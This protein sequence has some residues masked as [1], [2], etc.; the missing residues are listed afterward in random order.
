MGNNVLAHV[1]EINRFLGA[2]AA[3]LKPEGAA[4]FE[5]PYLAELLDKIEFDTIYH[6]HV[7]YYSLSSISNLAARANLEVFDVTQQAIHGGSLRVF[8]QHRGARPI[9][10]RVTKMLNGERQMGL[11]DPAHYNS[12]GMR[13]GELKRELLALLRSLKSEGKRLAAYGAPAKGNT[14]LNY[15]GIGTELLDFTVDMSPHKQGLYLP[16][17]RLPILAPSMLL[18]RAPDCAVILP[19]NIAD[20]IIGQQR[21]YQARGG[22]FIVPIPEPRILSDSRRAS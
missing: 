19:W 12:F 13:V 2:A 1:P 9:E 4:V 15:C 18:E 21:E 20:E 7:F 8:L 16:G 17:S 11:T 10:S 5:F 22:H 6:E 3:C 14:L